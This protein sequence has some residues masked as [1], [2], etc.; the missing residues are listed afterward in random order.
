MAELQV[1]EGAP[2]LKTVCTNFDMPCACVDHMP[3]CFSTP[4]RIRFGYRDPS[5]RPSTDAAREERVGTLASGSFAV[6]SEWTSATV[7]LQ[8]RNFVLCSGVMV[9]ERRASQTSNAFFQDSYMVFV[10]SVFNGFGVTEQ[11]TPRVVGLGEC[12]PPH[13]YPGPVHTI[14]PEPNRRGRSALCKAQLQAYR[15]LRIRRRDEQSK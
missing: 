1:L 6:K 15:G 11:H 10:I 9:V 5:V 13:T 7:F 12:I 3:Y 8:C 14:A 2:P 4:G